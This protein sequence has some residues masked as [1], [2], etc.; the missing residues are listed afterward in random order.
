MMKRERQNII[1]CYQIKIDQFTFFDPMVDVGLMGKAT[2]Y[3]I[4]IDLISYFPLILCGF[5]GG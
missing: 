2:M 5:T 3:V 1:D 4:K